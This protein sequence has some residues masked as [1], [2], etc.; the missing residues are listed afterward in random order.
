[1]S[2]N[3]EYV[4]TT[5]AET[6][7][8]FKKKVKKS[9]IEPLTY[10]SVHEWKKNSSDIYD[11]VKNKFSDSRKIIVRSSAI[12]ED[13]EN[14][15]FA[16]VFDS[17][18]D[19]NPKSEK[20]IK[21]SI[22]K[23][24][25]SYKIANNKNSKNQILIQ[26]Q[27][28]DIQTSGVIFS[29]SSDSAPYFIINY[30][31]GG[32]TTKTTH[33]VS[34]KMIKILR[35]VNFSK[36][37]KRWEKLLKAVLEIEKI[38]KNKKLDI[39]FGLNSKNDVVIFQVRPM[40]SIVKNL[41]NKQIEKISRKVNSIQREFSKYTKKIKDVKEELSIFSDMSDWNPSEIIGDNPNNLDFSLYRFLITKNTWSRSRDFLGYF[42]VNDKELMIRFGNKPYIHTNASFQSLIPKNF[43]TH[44]RE[45]IQCYY[46]KKLSEN[47]NLHDKVEFEILF[48]CYDF[49]IDSRLKELREFGFSKNEIKEIKENLREFT[50]KL[51]ENEEKT[52]SYCSGLLQNL[53]QERKEILKEIN[54]ASVSNKKLLFSIQKLLI[55]CRDFGAFPFSIMA[56]LSF[57]G[58]IL[59]KSY[60]KQISSTEIYDNFI[61][62]LETPLTEI[63]NAMIEY[64]EKNLGKA[65]FL[66][67]YGHL[68]PGTYDITSLTYKNND[69]ILSDIE[70]SKQ[71]KIK[72][73]NIDEKQFLKFSKN[74][75][76]LSSNKKLLSFISQ[77]IIQREKF[78]FEFTKNL[79]LVIELVARVGKDIGLSRSQLA[80]IDIETI[81]NSKNLNNKEIKENWKKIIKKW[82]LERI[83][84]NYISLPQLIFSRDDFNIIKYFESIP[85][86]ITN[87]NVKGSIF[88][89]HPSS[90]DINSIKNSI[91]VLENADPGYDWIFTKNP[92]GLIT[93]Y[94]GIA[95]HM[96]IRCAEIGLP[97]AIGC[98]EII[99]N[100]VKNS[101]K[102]QLDCKNK[103]IFVLEQKKQDKF[104]EEQKLLKSIGYIK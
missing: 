1:M 74:E 5:K 48:S 27:S 21:K 99:F 60:E 10:F 33:G 45:K 46:M 31:E 12:G 87:K 77:S 52:L 39:E 64:K 103:R 22:E 84:N 76:K 40:T 49:T 4:F 92:L 101:L 18:L 80:H 2:G 8:Y 55:S 32:S 14:S 9:Q 24:I 57:I 28:I 96:S 83:T 25:S 30:E 54:S 26:S 66:K 42:D 93:K 98:G 23:V 6:L 104:I 69:D 53:I 85:N 79:S 3:N 7:A 37:E 86:F 71:R 62:S 95:S 11:Y 94:G 78:K 19:V 59:L 56:R 68:R 34:N 90:S 91:I 65:D 47:P 82:E 16:G 41:E 43:S 58:S 36:L 17:I 13:S 75:L 51:L 88:Y 100:R 50:S 72:N 29:C 61:Q 67:K 97:A 70:F 38:T 15:S 63:Q 20:S 73:I 81:I 102:L 35:T 44:L 89:L